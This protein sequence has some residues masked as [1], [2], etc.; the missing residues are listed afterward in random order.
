MVNVV[1]TLGT[2]SVINTQIN[3]EVIDNIHYVRKEIS[4][5]ISLPCSIRQLKSLIDEYIDEILNA[6]IAMPSI[7]ESYIENGKLKY[8]SLYEGGNIIQ[9]FTIDTLTW[10]EGLSAIDAIINILIKAQ[11]RGIFLDPHPKNFVWNGQ[12]IH[13]VDFSPPYCKKFMEMRIALAS[14]EELEIMKKNLSYFGPQYLPYH[15]AGDFYNVDP[16]ISEEF[17]R[18]LFDRFVAKNVI[19]SNFDEFHSIAKRIRALEDLRLERCIYL[20]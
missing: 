14:E 11:K 13:Y 18:L 15:F 2:F 20:F 7:K 9:T 3:I 12:C 17:L 16:Y 1:D 5:N 8:L 19:D 6:G 10:G 4:P